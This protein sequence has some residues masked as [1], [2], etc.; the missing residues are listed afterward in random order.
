MVLFLKPN[1]FLIHHVIIM[2]PKYIEKEIQK[3][4]NF[5]DVEMMFD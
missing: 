1:R 3:K 2:F 4:N 5:D